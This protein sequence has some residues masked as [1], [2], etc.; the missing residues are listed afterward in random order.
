M[1]VCCFCVASSYVALVWLWHHMAFVSAFIHPLAIP[2]IFQRPTPKWL[3]D[4]TCCNGLWNMEWDTRMVWWWWYYN[5]RTYTRTSIAV[6]YR[7]LSGNGFQ[8]ISCAAFLQQPKIQMKS[9][10]LQQHQGIV[11]VLFVLTARR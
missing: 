5:T 3:A 10:L 7:E 9:Y 6:C 11:S 1:C 2:F 4:V 8:K